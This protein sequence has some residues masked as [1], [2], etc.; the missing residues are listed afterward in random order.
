MLVHEMTG[1]LQRILEYPAKG[2]QIAQAVPL[3]VMEAYDFLIA[4]G[5]DGHPVSE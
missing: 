4:Q 3:E 2:Y 1:D 5:F